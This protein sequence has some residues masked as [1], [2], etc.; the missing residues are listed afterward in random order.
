MPAWARTM[1]D[2]TPITHFIKVIRM[3]MLN[4]SGL[5][6]IKAELFYEILFAVGLNGWAIWNYK[7]TA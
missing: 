5:A 1:A 2:L 6:D 7:K 3:I 4:G